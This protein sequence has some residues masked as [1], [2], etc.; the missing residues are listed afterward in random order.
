MAQKSILTVARSQIGVKEYPANSNNVKYNT[1]YYGRKVSGPAYPWCA[2]FVD[3]CFHET[4]IES[5]I[6]G[7]N[8]K[9][10]CPSYVEW[11]KRE[12]RW[13]T[14][15]KYGALVL[16]DW[17]RDGIADHIGIVEKVINKYKIVTIEGNT[18]IGND[19]NGG[20]VMRRTRST[21]YVLGYIYVSIYA[22]VKVYAEG[23]VASTTGVRIH[24]A[25]KMFGT[26]TAE[27]IPYGKTLYCYGTN[28][29]GGF[30]W[31]RVD[32]EKNKWVRK[33]SLKDRKAL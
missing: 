19:S 9:A 14:Q 2:V 10:Y 17:D 15:P 13:G 24:N 16:Y 25:P 20:E 30:E 26:A 33:T 1:W 12:G 21:D 29:S 3:W 28:K 27:V 22:P 11:A 32:P 18:G 8:N 6:K 23:V 31:W 4:G 5:R 7:V